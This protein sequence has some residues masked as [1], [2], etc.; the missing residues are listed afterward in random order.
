MKIIAADGCKKNEPVIV[1]G[2]GQMQQ[3]AALPGHDN[4]AKRNIN[5]TE[6]KKIKNFPDPNQG[7]LVLIYNYSAGC[8]SIT[9]IIILVYEDEAKITSVILSV[10]TYFNI[11]PGK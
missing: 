2:N 9:M 4:C 7:L 1:P 11:L 10:N 3:M 8:S 5:A 6:K